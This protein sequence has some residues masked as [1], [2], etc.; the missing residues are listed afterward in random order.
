MTQ[1][2]DDKEATVKHRLE[3]Y[4]AQTQPL[5]DYYS[6]WA[7]TGNLPAPQYRRIAGTGSVDEISQR[8]L[9]ALR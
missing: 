7:K 3:V 9:A 6:N 5:V 4:R 1:R 8:A 2:E